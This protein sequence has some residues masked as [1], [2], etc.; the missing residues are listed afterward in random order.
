MSEINRSYYAV[1][2]ANVRYDKGLSANA[3]LLYGEITALCNE[4]GYCWAS[5][6]Y[7]AELYKV[8]KETISRWVSALTQ[9]GYI[10]TKLIYKNGK[11]VE[12]RRIYI[13]GKIN[14]PCVNNQYPIDEKVN[15]PIDEKVKENITSFNNTYNNMSGKAE[16]PFLAIV[17]HLNEKASKNYKHT[18]KKTQILIKARL[19]EGFK[20]KDFYAVID[21]KTKEWLGTQFENYLRPETLFGTKFESYLNQKDTGG[22][23]IEFEPLGGPK[24]RG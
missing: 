3:K 2:P 17:N 19:N 16:P 18:S 10:A 11:T 4:K 8:K 12:E 21:K 24:Y 23:E 22:D 15:T 20:E 14:T 6:A 7:F 1:I 5:N 13:D 9:K